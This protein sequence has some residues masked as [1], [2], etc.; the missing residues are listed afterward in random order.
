LRVTLLRI[1]LEMYLRGQ[2]GSFHF[3]GEQGF[4]RF[5]G[6]S[7]SVGVAG[8]ADSVTVLGGASNV[9]HGT[10]RAMSVAASPGFHSVQIRG[11]HGN[12][13]CS[14]EP[15]DRMSAFFT[16][17][18][19]CLRHKCACALFLLRI[20]TGVW[21]LLC[22]GAF[23]V[24]DKLSTRGGCRVTWVNGCAFRQAS[25]AEFVQFVSTRAWLAVLRCPGGCRVTG[26]IAG[27]IA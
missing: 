2:R 3:R 9:P 18:V 19:Q 4:R 26:S 7:Y 24:F 5:V 20:P 16:K 27:G 15:I 12:C 6:I 1:P 11:A 23:I 21:K 25:S 17:A 13:R 10:K 14:V 8:W 22:C